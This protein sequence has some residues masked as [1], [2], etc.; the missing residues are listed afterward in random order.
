MHTRNLFAGLFFLLLSMAFVAAQ[1]VL[2]GPPGN[3]VIGE[4]K[5]LTL[6]VR[7]PPALRCNNNMQIAAELSNL[8]KIPIVVLPASLAPW[9]RAPAVYYGEQ[10]IAEDGGDFNGMVGLAQM[11]D[12]IEIE[13]VAKQDRGGRLTEV[14]K[15]HEA[16]KSAIK[17]GN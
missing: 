13:G 8:Y 10:L 9:S 11:L 16:L 5:V 7:E 2:A 15:E 17:A 14:K 4:Q 6:V 1:P 12:V 3:T